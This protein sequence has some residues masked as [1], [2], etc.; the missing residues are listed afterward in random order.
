MAV[1]RPSKQISIFL[2]IPQVPKILDRDKGDIN[3]YYLVMGAYL[4]YGVKTQEAQSCPHPPAT[5][6]SCSWG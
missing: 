5:L 1:Q 6:G 4:L 3:L 2:V